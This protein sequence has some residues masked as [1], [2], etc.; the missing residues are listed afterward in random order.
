MNGAEG[1]GLKRPSVANV[2]DGS[3]SYLSLDEYVIVFLMLFCS[4]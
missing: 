4:S 1:R 2:D 3:S